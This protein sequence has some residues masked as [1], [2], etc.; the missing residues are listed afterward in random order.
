MSVKEITTAMNAPTGEETIFAEALRLP[1]NERP[2][3]LA[4]ATAGNAEL[5]RR[6]ESLLGSYEAGDFLEE[7]A[8]PQL[9]QTLHVTV[10]VTEK[11][12]DT[13]GRYKLLQQIGEGGCG[14]VYMAEQAEPVRRRVALK[15]IK[16][17][18]DTRSVIARFEAERQAL[19]MMDHPNIAK[20]IDAGATETGRP[21]FVMELV[22]GMK[23]TEYCDEKKLSTDER[24]NL[25]IQVCHAIQHA[26]QKGIIHRD[27]KPS[28]I[29]V[30]VNDG[31][32][33]PKVIDFGIAKAT[34]GQQL[35]DKTLFTAFEQ[36]I[37]T[38]AYMSPEQAVLTSLD[39][40]T[41]SDIYAL[42]VLLY[43]MLTGRTPFD[44]QELLA[45][46]LDEMRRAIREQ[47]PP[48]PSTRLS[49]LPGKDLS[50]TA[51][52]RGLD[53][54]KLVSELRGDLDW[55]VM[56]ALEKD[57]AR[58]Y[59]TANS[60][61]SDIERHLNHEP[62]VA[63]PPGRWY[64]FQKLVRRNKLVFAAGSAVAASLVI[65]LTVS[66]VLFFRE[67]AARARADEQTAIAEAVN[68]FLQ[69]DLLRQATSRSQAEAQFTPDPNLTVREALDRAALRIGDRFKD[70][71]LQEAAVRHAIGCS[72][73]GLGESER[74]IDQ[75][76]PA[77]DARRTRLGPDH[78][79][80]LKSRLNLALAYALGGKLDRALPL[81]EETLKLSKAALGPD[82]PDTL[83]AMWRL[84]EFKRS[85]PLHEETLNLRIA[86]LGPN[87]PDTLRSMIGLAFVYTNA[88]KVDQAVPL[89]EEALK[90]S[91]ATLGS[92]HPDT[93]GA[94]N[95][96]ASCYFDGGRLDQATSLYEENL[97]R[98][99]DRLGP[100]DTSTLWAMHNLALVYGRRADKNDQAVA[101]LEETVTRGKA[102]LGPDH[103]YTLHW[104][105]SLALAYS[106]A[107]KRDLALPL[108][109]ETLRLTKAKLG[110]DD[111]ATL[112][113]MNNLALAYRYAGKSDL[114]LELQGEALKL[115]RAKL[116]PDDPNTPG[117]VQNLAA[118]YGEAGKLDLALP[119]YEEVLKLRR[120]KLGPDHKDTLDSMHK[121]AVAY[122]KAD[123]FDKGLPLLEEVLKRRVASHGP[124]HPNTM[125]DLAWA[126][127]TARKF[128]QA[129]SVRKDLVELLNAREGP[130]HPDT[131]GA[132]S[133]LASVYRDAGKPELAL[134]LDEETLRL[135]KVKLGP[136]HRETL[137]SMN[138]L[139]LTQQ[140]LG[141][142]DEALPL[143]EETRKLMKAR[144]APDDEYS[145][146]AT[147]NLANALRDTGKHEEAVPLREELLKLRKT[148]RGPDHPGTLAAMGDLA[149]AYREAGRL[150][151]ALPVMEET[152]KLQKARLGTGDHDTLSTMNNL[153]LL[154]GDMGK[155]DQELALHE[156]TFKLMKT[157]L[158]PTHGDTLISMKNLALTYR[159]AGKLKQLEAMYR[160]Q[161]AQQTGDVCA[162]K[163]GLGRLLLEAAKTNRAN[164]RRREE[165]LCE[166]EQ[167]V[168]DYLDEVRS[169]YAD[170]RL[171]LADKIAD[172][173]EFRYRQGN[174]VDAE[175]LYREI[176]EC[177]RARLRADHKDV[178][179]PTASLAR[180]LSDWAWAER[181]HSQLPSAVSAP[182]RLSPVNSQLPG[183]RAR[184]AEQ[185][186]REVLVVRLRDGASSWR[187]GDVKSRL[188]GAL[189]SVAV[190]DPAMNAEG[191]EAKLSEAESLLLEG[192]ER[193]QS[194]ATDDKY[195]R[196][197]LQRL[198][199]LY[200]AW[201]KPAKR[202]EWQ[203]KLER[204]DK[205]QKMSPA[206]G[207]LTQETSAINAETK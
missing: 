82:H 124:D 58:R 190:T 187:V 162:A 39:I 189:V 122:C 110:P 194:G 14:V 105:A 103:P 117:F 60:M 152:F 93:M 161:L 24:L 157:A 55:I 73:N 195:K 133:N 37:G 12:G 198:V 155:L 92:D 56:K 141:R 147:T 11:A 65:G 98:T 120:A 126:Y 13:I 35:T 150:D 137:G 57:R 184:E 132:M 176:V 102:R 16:L 109:E 151:E 34:S 32:P 27:I 129:I 22:R 188:G 90:L 3:W 170:D 29:L 135:R 106:E 41:R 68:D 167:L 139:A 33:V 107:G 136:D 144:L 76:Q 171:K 104:M 7:A 91:K 173:A 46:G 50:T 48:K 113:A 178:I 72:F 153:A 25:F 49:T 4:Q 87:H 86:R 200:E 199:R 159:K 17:G 28:N 175:P 77:W 81:I 112:R 111:P 20:V 169:R 179:E 19:A 94:M 97:K 205:E 53:A 18:M 131:L 121:L 21:Y 128:D 203:Q 95:A 75:L 140:N 181:T 38:P 79:D 123:K 164:P 145:L 156:E 108:H 62:V 47:E 45:I 10:P 182:P 100:D 193:V 31:A 154:Y 64:R 158:G 30:T 119:L 9:R 54:P 174:Y 143:L 127:E 5:R 138:N 88:G 168:R 177:R 172:V 42:G 36:F 165:L 160:E 116:G 202:A 8:A 15:I 67:R 2:A 85:L 148:R 43:E 96:L 134:P 101:L 1:A 207:S 61:A 201:N 125:K 80:T 130:D 59:D 6:V 66:T 115:A 84:A 26:H 99:K 74:A 69:E 206:S 185:L 83:T 114:A 192:C 142:L 191:R 204:F 196:D 180:V 78:P 51:Q 166:G 44:A 163:I 63:C 149:L 89:A 186:L 197:A 118:I 70:Q 71:P 183:T 23:I 52:R 40:D 146:N